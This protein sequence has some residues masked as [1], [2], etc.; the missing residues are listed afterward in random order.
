[1]LTKRQI[2]TGISIVL[3]IAIIF[4][5]IR[6]G[7]E[8]PYTQQSSNDTGTT[9]LQAD[10]VGRDS[11]ITCH[12]KEFRLWQGSDHDLAMQSANEQTVL[13]DFSGKTL[14]HFGVTSEFYRRDTRYYVRTEGPG[15]KM[16]EFQVLYTFGIRPLQQYLVPFPGGRLQVLPLCWDTRPKSQGGQRWFHIYQHERIRPDD[17]LY[18]THVTETWN[19]M[20][21]ECHSTDLRKNYDAQSDSFHTTYSEIDVSCEACHGPGSQH[22]VWARSQQKGAEPSDMHDKG[23]VITFPTRSEAAWVF[24]DTSATA[25]RAAPKKDDHLITMCARCHSRRSELTDD[26]VFGKS[27]LDTHRP[28]LLVEDLYFPDGQ[29][30]DE[31]YVWGSFL[32]SKMYQMGVVCN[33]CHDSHSMRILAKDNALCY[34]CHQYET[35]GVRSHHFHNPDSTGA[36]CVECH[37]PERTYMVVDPR[38]DHSIR[39]PRPDLTITLGTPNACNKCHAD[40]D[41]KWALAAAL[42][43][44]GSDF[45]KKPEYGHIFAS[46]R[47]HESDVS[48][49]LADLL[50]DRTQAV[51]V[52][53]TA[54]QEMGSYLNQGTLGLLLDASR[55]KEPLIRYAAL[56]ALSDA[57]PDVKSSA[58]R[59]LLNDPVKL[60]RTEAA[61]LI[62]DL[63]SDVLAG[64]E[65]K[66]YESA[67]REY[68][69]TQNFNAEHPSAQ[70]NL[71]VYYT[72]RGDYMRAE[73]AYRNA[74]R[75]EPDLAFAYINLSDLY[76]IQ[77]RNSEG[78]NLLQTAIEKIPQNANLYYAL[79]LARIREKQPLQAVSA[80]EQANLIEPENAHFQYA[81]ALAY[82]AAGDREK[83]IRTLYRSSLKF[84]ENK[85]ILYALAT[86]YRDLGD[87]K[88]AGEY[89]R[90]LLE[91]DPGNV[92][93]QQFMD[94]ILK[95]RPEGTP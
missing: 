91:T 8:R 24:S 45:E 5:L 32:Q 22:M 80:L 43:W 52:R 57:P 29:I 72:R 34:R 44:Y 73:N 14:I 4:V 68:L 71:G 37:M 6:T 85:E 11:C 21:A 78:I 46:A 77:N 88:K 7:G 30:Q 69:D 84:P 19:Y 23:L 66:E 39:I 2:I 15:G 1:M 53:A 50:T 40:K 41:A 67:I 12:Q 92:G 49:M 86:M 82:D 81:L 27:L 48:G 65:Q 75:L 94:Q 10:Y 13:G 18:W 55:E 74:L 51:I 87:L 54:A 42:K 90:K 20:C 28:T 62:S 95:E 64:A 17:M 36:L 83:A 9:A 3:F 25:H 16:M 38:R 93:Y 26:Y 79:A 60:V 61:R 63:P 89:A 59:N 33:D 58:A 35:Y 47:A 76:R 31:V 70:L 56:N